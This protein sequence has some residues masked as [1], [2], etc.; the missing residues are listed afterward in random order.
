MEVQ[1]QKIR[2]KEQKQ[3]IDWFGLIFCTSRIKQ[4][5]E[6]W[7]GIKRSKPKSK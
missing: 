5:A 2:T 7:K 6:I 3:L 4:I 1:I